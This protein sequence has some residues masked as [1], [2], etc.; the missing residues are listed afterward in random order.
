METIALN[1]Y[2]EKAQK[3]ATNFIDLYN[4]ATEDYKFW[5]KDF[6][7]HFGYY[8]PFKT[9]PFKRDTMLNEMNNQIFKRLKPKKIN[10]LLI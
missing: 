5:S 3:T 2:K 7:M 4:E 1:T 6:N 10:C 8:I 9:N